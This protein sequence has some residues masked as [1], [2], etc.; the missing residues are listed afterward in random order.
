MMHPKQM[1]FWPGSWQVEENPCVYRDMEIFSNAYA[2]RE[3]LFN[4]NSNFCN[5]LRKPSFDI[6][7]F[8]FVI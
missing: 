5:R 6:I 4:S 7:V 2:M 3:A 8:K 1:F